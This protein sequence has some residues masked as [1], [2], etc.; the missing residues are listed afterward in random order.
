[1]QSNIKKGLLAGI[2]A[3]VIFGVSY[4]AIKIVFNNGMTFAGLLFW[5]MVIAIAILWALLHFVI[6]K[7]TL[8]FKRWLKL[9]PLA[10][11]DPILYYI[12]E[13]IGVAKTGA[14]IS[15][16]I[17][18]MI[19]IAAL[20]ASR[21]FLGEKHTALQIMAVLLSVSG[22]VL[23][24]FSGG[25][26]GFTAAPSGYLCLLVA[27]LSAAA[28]QVLL[29]LKGEGYSAAEVTL[30][31]SLYG[32]IFYGGYALIEAAVTQD[33]YRLFLLPFDCPLVLVMILSLAVGSSVIAFLLF[34]YC[35]VTI[36]PTR[37]SA[38]AGIMTVTSI[39]CGVLI[40]KESLTPPQLIGAAMVICGAWAANRFVAPVIT[41]PQSAEG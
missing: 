12:G 14:A 37:C 9:L 11:C 24:A 26:E 22:V 28:Y 36:G 38:L 35:I 41:Q 27:L 31:I 18:A 15:G 21:I 23:I 39:L 33:F 29:R 32:T 1:M 7:N 5:R 3:N 17:I 34:N 13:S 40:L 10:I 16:T 2:I 19:P 4:M 6:R 30:G 8:T 25:E 20:L